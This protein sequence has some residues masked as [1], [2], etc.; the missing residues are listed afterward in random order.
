MCTLLNGVERT[1][2]LQKQTVSNVDSLY[3]KLFDSLIIYFLLDCT[4]VC[5][6]AIIL[7]LLPREVSL[8]WSERSACVSRAAL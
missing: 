2:F 5:L 6:N 1:S 3:A 7:H 4:L 8:Y